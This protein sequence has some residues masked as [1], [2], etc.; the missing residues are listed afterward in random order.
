M[1]GRNSVLSADGYKWTGTA[2]K[3]CR[4]KV[5]GDDE[6][7]TEKIRIPDRSN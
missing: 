2:F 3:P 5:V 6:K 7:L 4:L 1:P